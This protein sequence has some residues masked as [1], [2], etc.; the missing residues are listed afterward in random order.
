MAHKHLMEVP[1]DA[2]AGGSYVV[3]ILTV[4]RCCGKL[5]LAELEVLLFSTAAIMVF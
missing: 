2:D 3:S 1:D 4:V 5:V